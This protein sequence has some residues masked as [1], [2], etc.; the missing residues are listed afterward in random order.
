M[1]QSLHLLRQ[2][3]TKEDSHFIYEMKK[4]KQKTER[5]MEVESDRFNQRH[6]LSRRNTFAGTNHI[7]QIQTPAT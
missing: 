1:K 7:P 5:I 2:D 3:S 6:S 4:I